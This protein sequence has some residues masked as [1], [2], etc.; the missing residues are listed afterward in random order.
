[1]AS[2]EMVLLPS[3][4]SGGYRRKGAG[5]LYDK[6][7]QANG[8][9]SFPHESLRHPLPGA[10]MV[11]RPGKT[12]AGTPFIPPPMGWGLHLGQACA[13]VGQDLHWSL[14]LKSTVEGK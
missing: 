14:A 8:Y 2:P 12:A 7:A 11:W 4:G 13:A 5:V 9:I 1:M 10:Q 6:A 3:Q